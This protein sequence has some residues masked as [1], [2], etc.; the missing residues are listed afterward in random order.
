MHQY[1]AIP[2]RLLL[3]RTPSNAAAAA[4]AAPPIFLSARLAAST[5]DFLSRSLTPNVLRRRPQTFRSF[6]LSTRSKKHRTRAA[7][8]RREAIQITLSRR[9]KSLTHIETMPSTSLNCF[10]L[11]L[12]LLGGFSLIVSAATAATL[13]DMHTFG[14]TDAYG[15]GLSKNSRAGTTAAKVA[16]YPGG[17]AGVRPAQI[18][19]LTTRAADTTTAPSMMIGSQ[20]AADK[21]M[22]SGVRSDGAIGNTTIFLEAN[23]PAAH[24][25]TAA[26]LPRHSAKELQPIDLHRQG[27]VARSEPPPPLT[28]MILFFF[29]FFCALRAAAALLAGILYALAAPNDTVRAIGCI[30]RPL[31]RPPADRLGFDSCACVC[32]VRRASPQEDGFRSAAAREERTDRCR[33]PSPKASQWYCDCVGSETLHL[34]ASPSGSVDG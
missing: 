10:P 6:A 28:W 20:F 16:T 19:A 18:G 30:T 1:V 5:T 29:F 7:D 17:A 25:A 26:A 27:V 15:G 23:R 34:M 22:P 9:A 3:W 13:A 11:P 4:S 8:S 2:L 14:T 24:T 33:R 12:P 32:A 31:S 21:T